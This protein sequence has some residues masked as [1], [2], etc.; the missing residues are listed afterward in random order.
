MEAGWKYNV[1]QTCSC[2]RDWRLSVSCGPNLGPTETQ[3]TSVYWVVYGGTLKGLRVL[4]YADRRYSFWDSKCEFLPSCMEESRIDLV[5]VIHMFVKI[6]HGILCMEDIN[7][8]YV[9]SHYD[10][11]CSMARLINVLVILPMPFWFVVKIDAD[12]LI[13]LSGWIYNFYF[14]DIDIIHSKFSAMVL[15]LFLQM[16]FMFLIY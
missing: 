16:H 10:V 6:R 1:D 5:T 3:R 14:V 13:R 11:W 2:P 8:V 4:H 7:V 12:S 9:S 15:T